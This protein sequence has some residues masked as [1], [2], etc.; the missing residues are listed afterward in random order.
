[1]APM[2]GEG[3]VI[4]FVKKV[5]GCAYINSE[6]LIALRLLRQ[7]RVHVRVAEKCGCDS[8]NVCV[9]LSQFSFDFE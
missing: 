3:V 7:T 6:Y 9:R 5:Q 2:D 1:M 4:K 8:T